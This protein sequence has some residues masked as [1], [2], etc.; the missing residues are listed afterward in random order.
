MVL[1]ARSCSGRRWRTS[2][3]TAEAAE[4]AYERLLICSA[5]RASGKEAAWSVRR[6]DR[7][8][9]PARKESEA[10]SQQKRVDLAQYQQQ[11]RAR[12]ALLPQSEEG[13]R[14][15]EQEVD[16]APEGAR[17]QLT[18]QWMASRAARSSRELMCSSS[19]QGYDTSVRQADA[20]TVL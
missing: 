20:E 17:A 11:A 5:R 19:L 13:D 14:R 1:M 3:S 6:V 9:Q 2:S 18:A 8:G 15:V 4:A 10:T 12:A 16:P 7:R